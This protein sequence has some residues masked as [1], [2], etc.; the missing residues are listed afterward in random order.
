MVQFTDVPDGEY[1]V[2][3]SNHLRG[4]WYSKPP[5]A[6]R[7]GQNASTRVVLRRPA[8]GVLRF[9]VQPAKTD[10]DT[11]DIDDESLAPSPDDRVR[12]MLTPMDADELVYASIVSGT[13]GEEVV[14]DTLVAGMTY[15]ARITSA[16]F[17]RFEGVF[18]AA[19]DGKS[20]VHAIDLVRAQ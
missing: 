9:A 12:I 7:D 5:I 10:A 16:G 18:T 13:L 6:I 1:R 11:G 8:R 3:R 15:L 2:G 17:E 20:S 19:A 4:G 14:A